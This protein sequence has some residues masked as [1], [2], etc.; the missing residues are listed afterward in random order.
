MPTEIKTLSSDGKIV[1]TDRIGK[2]GVKLAGT[3]EV[4][5]WWTERKEDDK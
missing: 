1:V 5:K 2:D 3:P 4:M